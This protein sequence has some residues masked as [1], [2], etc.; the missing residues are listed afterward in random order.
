MPVNAKENRR[1]EEPRR[2]QVATYMTEVGADRV[3]EAADAERRSISDW[4]R[5]LIERE[6]AI[7]DSNGDP[8]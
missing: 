5:L 6:L 3:R 1:A 4:L 8:R 7:D 2:I